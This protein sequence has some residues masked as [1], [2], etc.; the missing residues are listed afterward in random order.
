MNSAWAGLPGTAWSEGWVENAASR[1]LHNERAEAWL[2]RLK[3]S[4][5]KQKSQDLIDL[6]PT[7]DGRKPQIK[8]EDGRF[9]AYRFNEQQNE[10]EWVTDSGSSRIDSILDRHFSAGSGLS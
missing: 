3:A 7:P 8:L 5:Q 9:C 6:H 1:A 10:S 4:R 2:E